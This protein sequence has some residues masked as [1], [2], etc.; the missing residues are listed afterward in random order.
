MQNCLT[1][2][3]KIVGPVEKNWTTCWETGQPVGEHA[4]PYLECSRVERW[5]RR[6]ACCP[7][8]AGPDRRPGGPGRCQGRPGP[9]T[10]AAPSPA[11]GRTNTTQS[12]GP[13]RPLIYKQNR[14]SS[15]R[16]WFCAFPYWGPLAE[17]SAAK[18]KRSQ[19]NVCTVYVYCVLFSP[20]WLYIKTVSC[21]AT[22]ACRRR[23]EG[24]P[25]QTRAPVVL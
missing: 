11:S 14:W 16:E 23:G 6:S 10:A 22:L 4:I 2:C 3:K 25:I 15:G 18:L 9:H 20:L 5:D 17:V 21:W 7:S 24:A 19:Q 12:L 1:C 8:T 13:Q